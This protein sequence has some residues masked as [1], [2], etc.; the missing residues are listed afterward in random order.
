MKKPLIYLLTL[1]LVIA[2]TVYA[3]AVFNNTVFERIRLTTDDLPDGYTYG[4]LPDFARL[5]LGN[6]PTEMNA[7]A[8]RK[9][10]PNVYP[11]GDPNAVGSMHVSSS[12]AKRTRMTTTLSAGCL[13][14]ATAHQPGVRLPS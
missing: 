7:A 1:M 6:N 14:F 12:P 8:I 11:N 4:I 10:V 5:V 9:L 13:S 3:Q 2:G